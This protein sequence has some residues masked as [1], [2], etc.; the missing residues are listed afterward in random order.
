M[1][2]RTKK[3]MNN[4]D[5]V[6]LRWKVEEKETES[7]FFLLDKEEELDEF[8][9]LVSPI[10]KKKKPIYPLKYVKGAKNVLLVVRLDT[11]TPN[12]KAKMEWLEENVFPY[13]VFGQNRCL[14]V[15]GSSCYVLTIGERVDLRFCFFF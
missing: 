8:R 1:V 15:Y 2:Y 5:Y 11:Q 9:E 14:V 7:K 3:R 13:G 6:Q 4:E 12:L 10:L